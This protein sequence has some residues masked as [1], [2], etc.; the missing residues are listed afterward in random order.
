MVNPLIVNVPSPAEGGTPLP[1]EQVYERY[2]F[3]VFRFVYKHID[4]RHEAEDLASEVFLYCYKNYERYDPLKSSISTWLFLVAKSKLK[5]Y[6]RDKKNHLDISD[7]EDW[8]IT[9]NCDLSRAIYLEQLRSFLTGQIKRLPE[10]QQQA[11]IMRYF[12]E[13]DFDEIANALNTTAGNVRV[14]LTRAVAKLRQNLSDS[15]L[16]WSV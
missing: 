9:E 3:D 2:Y 6:Y 12:H 4:N 8:L 16:D 11:V 14:M 1:F 5:T 7:F 13:K 10:R 15:E